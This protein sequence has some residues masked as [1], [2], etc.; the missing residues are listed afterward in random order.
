MSME[1]RTIYDCPCCG[2]K[3]EAVITMHAGEDLVRRAKTPQGTPME[4]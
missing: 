1:P 4:I 3:Y 2:Q